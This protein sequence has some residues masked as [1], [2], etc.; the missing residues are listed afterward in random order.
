MKINKINEKS[1]SEAGIQISDLPNLNALKN[2]TFQFE[3]NF[4]LPVLP[5]EPGLIVVRGARQFG[6]ST[7]LEGQLLKAAQKNGAGTT[8]Y[9][10]GDAIDTSKTLYQELLLLTDLMNSKNE[11]RIFIDEITSVKNWENAIKQLWDEGHTR[12]TLIVTT[13]SNAKDL[14]RGTELLPGRKGKLARNNYIFIPISYN[15]FKKHIPKNM[16][17]N[18]AI[19]TY[20]ISGGSPVAAAS[21]LSSGCI[22]PYVFQLVEDWILG[23]VSLAGKQRALALA[24]FAKLYERGASPLSLTKIARET[25]AANNTVVLS[26]LEIFIDILCLNRSFAFD[27]LESNIL[28]RKES[29]FH[30]VNLLAAATFA[31]NRLHK[32][33]D[34]LSLP[35]ADQGIWLEWLVAQELW[36]R[37]MKNGNS[38]ESLI[39]FAKYGDKEIDFISDTTCYECKR[40]QA[41]AEEF[42]WF[43]RAFP[44][45]ELIVICATPFSSGKIKGITLHDFL[46]QCD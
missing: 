23:A 9:L 41:S 45:K 3:M 5:S 11:N 34:F 16:E 2:Q 30:F 18:V 43:R 39:P 25:G 4:G 14:I 22:E 26:Y 46:S 8:F 10:N 20:L 1:L 7:W 17:S 33:S 27:L 21:L 12:N 38:L 35:E 37:K 32:A 42:E 36:R 28:F 13:G 40:G 19:A 6:K 24:L 29:K 44:Q 31:K 15:E